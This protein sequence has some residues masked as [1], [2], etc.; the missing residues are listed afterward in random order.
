MGLKTPFIALRGP[1]CLAYIF[2][3]AAVVISGFPVIS[4]G[5][6]LSITFIETNSK[7]HRNQ[8]S[9]DEVPFGRG[10][11]L[12]LGRVKDAKYVNRLNSLKGFILGHK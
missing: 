3:A 6:E 8:S 12:V 10:E 5:C 2:S 9:E 7:S 1:P 11:L 4:C